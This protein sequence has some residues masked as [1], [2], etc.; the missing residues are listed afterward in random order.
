MAGLPMMG[1]GRDR[2]A[3]GR[4]C[5]STTSSGWNRERGPSVGVPGGPLSA[6]CTDGGWPSRRTWPPPSNSLWP[7]DWCWRPICR[8][9]GSPDGSSEF[10]NLSPDHH[11]APADLA[12][13]AA[14]ETGI[15]TPR[16]RWSMTPDW[17]EVWGWPSTPREYAHRI[18]QHRGDTSQTWDL[19]RPLEEPLGP[20]L[21]WMPSPT[22]TRMSLHDSDG[23]LEMVSP[24][25]AHHWDD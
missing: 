25:G 4:P 3:R 19:R 6:E 17:N 23:R 5:G 8:M 16:T 9:A 1:M 18:R 22:S 13:E 20:D 11:P 7:N 12:P 24:Y 10:G 21:S 15:I 2:A 14:I